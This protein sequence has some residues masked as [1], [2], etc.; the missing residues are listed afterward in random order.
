MSK[1]ALARECLGNIGVEK[2]WYYEE[3]TMAG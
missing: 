2:N 3:G 1:T